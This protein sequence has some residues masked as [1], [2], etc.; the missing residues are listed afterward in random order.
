M[1]KGINL[2]GAT[3]NCSNGVTPDLLGTADF[4]DIMVKVPLATGVKKIVCQ[5]KAEDPSA[6]V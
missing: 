6:G 4:L 1:D 5:W 3:G 2:L